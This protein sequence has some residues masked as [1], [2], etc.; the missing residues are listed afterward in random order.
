MYRDYGNPSDSYEAL[1]IFLRPE[2]NFW[3]LMGIGWLVAIITSRIGIGWGEWMRTVK[4]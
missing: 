3:T 1:S 4:R 2:N